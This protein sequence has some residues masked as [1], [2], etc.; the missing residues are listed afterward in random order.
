[1]AAESYPSVAELGA[2]IRAVV[3]SARQDAWSFM[4]EAQPN[5]S[6]QSRKNTCSHTPKKERKKE[7][8][9]E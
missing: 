3:A 8:K 1:M 4:L 9:K 5:L 2:A 6:R 7:S